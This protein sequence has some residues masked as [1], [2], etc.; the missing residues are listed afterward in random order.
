MLKIII[1]FLVLI[2]YT[3]TDLL[4]LERREGNECIKLV[5]QSEGSN[6]TTVS[7]PS[8]D[9]SESTVNFKLI[10]NCD[11]PQSIN[12]LEILVDWVL[13][14]RQVMD[15]SFIQQDGT[16]RLY[17]EPIANQ[18]NKLS[19]KINT[20]F[21]T[22]L[23]CEETKIKPNTIINT[24]ITQRVDSRIYDSKCHSISFSKLNSLNILGNLNIVP[25]FPEN[26]RSNITGSLKKEE[27]GTNI[28]FVIN[29][30]YSNYVIYNLPVGEYFDLCLQNIFD[31]SLGSFYLPK[32]DPFQ[33]TNKKTT[34]LNIFYSLLMKPQYIIEFIFFQFEGVIRLM[35]SSKNSEILYINTTMNISH[36]MKRK[37]YFLQNEE[38]SISVNAGWYWQAEISNKVISSLT[39]NIT[40]NFFRSN[41]NLK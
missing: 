3:I 23:S 24:F 17:F 1:I 16:P 2:P 21:C 11:S 20:P 31:P 34:Q 13:N 9:Y 39:K 8:D 25:Y 18:L 28:N 4:F 19:L 12:N 10:N 7:L 22:G 36:G 38:V 29:Y 37:F 6:C 33:I 15:F 30:S 26:F 41:N 14:G 32:F 5:I 35:F 27:S 40:I